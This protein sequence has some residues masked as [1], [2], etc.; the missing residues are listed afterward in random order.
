[1]IHPIDV[2]TM[3][4]KLARM[5][6]SETAPIPASISEDATGHQQLSSP[7]TG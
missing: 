1:M 7:L 2:K 6:R 5:Q 3:G 4:M